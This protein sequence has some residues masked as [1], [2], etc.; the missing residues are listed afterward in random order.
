MASLHEVEQHLRNPT[1]SPLAQHIDLP[2]I[3]PPSPISTPPIAN[4]ES[5]TADENNKVSPSIRTKEIH[6]LI[7]DG[8]KAIVS[9]SQ[10]MITE[11]RSSCAF[12]GHALERNGDVSRAVLLWVMKADGLRCIG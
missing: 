10:L 9:R 1:D 12:D 6:E 5:P 2:A 7:N 8:V 4:V 3:H 11:P